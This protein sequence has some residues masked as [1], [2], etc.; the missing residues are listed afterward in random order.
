MKSRELRI[1]LTQKCNFNCTFC[2]KEGVLKNKKELLNSDDYCFVFNYLRNTNGWTTVSVTGGEPLCYPKIDHLL[3][4]LNTLNAQITL[5]SNGSMLSSHLDIC[6]YLE[7]LTISVHTMNNAKYQQITRNPYSIDLLKE[8]LKSVRKH[9]PD[10]HIRFNCT[11]VKGV[12]S[13]ENDIMDI[14]HFAET[15][16]ASV[17][18]IELLPN[19]KEDEKAYVPIEEIE[20][21]LL[22]H[23]FKLS[24]NDILQK[25]YTNGKTT[26]V[27]ARIV[28]SL[29]KV[30]GTSKPHC[31]DTNSIFLAS[32]GTIKPCMKNSFEI[33][34]LEEIKTRDILNLEKKMDIFYNRVSTLCPY[35]KKEEE[36]NG[37]AFLRVGVC[38]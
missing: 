4:Q 19:T 25:I 31:T 15:I 30:L 22:D 28:C 13:S 18:V 21:I 1:L 6:K 26:V 27:L 2:H 33:D 23:K 10:L 14:I 16:Q 37:K 35:E 29:S 20:T 24:R 9:Y 8:N 36:T 34:V 11:L 3:Q 7:K 38:Y 12:N 32:D 17:K 5:V